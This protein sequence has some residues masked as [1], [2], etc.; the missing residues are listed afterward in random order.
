MSE[1]PK[2]QP[3][4]REQ[5]AVFLVFGAVAVIF[6]VLMLVITQQNQITPTVIPT[7][8]EGTTASVV[9][10][11]A[12]I[13]RSNLEGG[14]PVLGSPEAKLLLVEF[15]N[16]R[17]PHCYDYKPTIE[18]IIDQLVKPGK[19]KL[20]IV[21][22]F[23]SAE[24]DSLL[25]VHAALCADKQQGFWQMHDALFDLQRRTAFTLPV[26]TET[27]KNL[28]LDAVKLEACIRGN[29]VVETIQKGIEIT[30]AAGVDGTPTL[31]YSTDGGKTLQWFQVQGKNFGTGVTPEMV[32]ALLD[33]LP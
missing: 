22:L 27:A 6:L 19:V 8:G 32:A 14:Q 4:S 9:D 16:F 12:N 25:A 7:V 18:A 20:A 15:T 31:L 33:T 23:F 2:S 11:Y 3:R 26:L 29:E 13:P 17:C 28:G 30:V 5:A 21:P 1:Q 24:D 10:R